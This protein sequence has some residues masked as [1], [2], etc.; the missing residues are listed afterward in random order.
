[1]KRTLTRQIMSV[2]ICLLACTVGACFLVNST[3]LSRYYTMQKKHLLVDSYEELEEACEDNTLYSS[4]FDAEFENMCS[5]QNLEILIISADGSALRTSLFDTQL[6]Q[7]QLRDAMFSGRENS[8]I[9]DETDDYRIQRIFD[10]GMDDEEY[11]I[12]W[13][14]LSDGNVILMRTAME[15][16]RESVEISNH[17]LLYIAVCAIVIGACVSVVISRRI[18][19]PILQLTDISEKMVQLDFDAKYQREDRFVKRNGKKR[20]GPVPAAMKDN[21]IDELGAHMNELSEALEKTISELKAAN[22]ELMRDIEKKEEIDEMRK[23]FL[24][25][26]SHE[27]KTPIAIIQGY[28]EGLQECVNDD[29]ESRQFYCDVIVDE[30]KKMNQMVQKLLTLNRLEFGNTQLSIERFDVTELIM[31]VVNSS[32]ILMDQKGIRIEMNLPKEYVWADEFEIEE[33]VTNYLSNAINHAEGEK[34]IRIFYTKKESTLRV[35]VF[36]TGEPIP[37]D[38]LDKIWIKFYKVDKARTREYGGSGIGLSIVKAIMESHHQD[39]GV[40]NRENGVEFWFELDQ[41][42]IYGAAKKKE[43]PDLKALPSGD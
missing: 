25:N 11:L 33:V 4:S 42:G 29:P 36:N 27:L 10:S 15:S 1:M 3:F 16:I 9:L 2:I 39:Y 8:E 28:A 7:Q 21:E 43:E 31:G 34:V 13:G 26:V 22:N 17:F 40:I 23:E 35:S 32:H 37:E 20:K 30:A 5:T 18:T 24:S 41:A 14:T 12:L 38:S 19:R 6:I